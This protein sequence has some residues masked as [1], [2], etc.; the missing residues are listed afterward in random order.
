MWAVRR[1]PEEQQWDG[2]RIKRIKGSP[3]NWKIDAG[4]EEETTEDEMEKKEGEDEFLE[5]P[6]GTRT[7]EKRS[8]Y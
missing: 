1:L 6:T 8:L 4:P 5:I 3:K 7:G 2:E